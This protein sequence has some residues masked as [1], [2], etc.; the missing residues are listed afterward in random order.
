MMRFR[1]CG[2]ENPVSYVPVTTCAFG[3][4]VRGQEGYT[5]ECVGTPGCSPLCQRYHVSFVS[6]KDIHSHLPEG[7]G[8]RC[9]GDQVCS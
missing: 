1:A 6:R 5:A 4:K 3:R 8:R 7:P 2:S 9:G